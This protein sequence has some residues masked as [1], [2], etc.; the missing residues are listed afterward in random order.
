M[1][2]LHRGRA[3]ISPVGPVSKKFTSVHN[4]LSDLLSPV[5]SV[6]HSQRRVGPVRG[7]MS[8]VDPNANVETCKAPDTN[9]ADDNNDIDDDY[10]D[11]DC[12]NSSSCHLTAD[13]AGKLFA[14]SSQ[15]DFIQLDAEIFLKLSPTLPLAFTS[16][17]LSGSHCCE[18][19]S[20]GLTATGGSDYMAADVND[21]IMQTECIE[22]NMSKW[23]HVPLNI[24]SATCDIDSVSV[25]QSDGDEIIL[26]DDDVCADVTETLANCITHTR[27]KYCLLY[28][29]DAA[30]E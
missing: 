14:T 29:S 11:D 9:D 8:F 17:S 5:L 2:Q 23:K 20:T 19:G 6:K 25:A 15:S 27:I 18:D 30:D 22:Y 7:H 4:G 26:L 28:T 21:N 3:V 1:Y 16:S 13:G 10:A 12:V 24:S